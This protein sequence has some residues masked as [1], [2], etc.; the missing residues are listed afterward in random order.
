MHKVHHTQKSYLTYPQCGLTTTKECVN[1]G[2][3][4]L[5]YFKV[6]ASSIPKS[7]HPILF[8]SQKLSLHMITKTQKDKF[9]PTLASAQ[10]N[11]EIKNSR[12]FSQPGETVA[13]SQQ[14]QQKLLLEA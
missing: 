8:Y 11:K 6:S 14:Q 12:A 7:Q 1:Q 13:A 9:N 2:F 4:S 5:H 10:K 3:V